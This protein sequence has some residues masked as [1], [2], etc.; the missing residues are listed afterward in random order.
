MEDKHRIQFEAACSGCIS[1][2]LEEWPALNEALQ[3][4]WLYLH[5]TTDATTLRRI[6]RL[7]LEVDAIQSPRFRDIEAE[8]LKR[9]ELDEFD[10]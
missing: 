2:T 3:A 4:H 10:V 8:F 9:L 5:H 1:G 7:L 6:C